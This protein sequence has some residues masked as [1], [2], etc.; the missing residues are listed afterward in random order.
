VGV[1]VG[2]HEVVEWFVWWLLSKAFVF[3]VVP[4]FALVALLASYGNLR[5]A[6]DRQ[7]DDRASRWIRRSDDWTPD[8]TT[9]DRYAD[10]PRDPRP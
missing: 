8:S 4:L 6:R 5:S 9:W 10:D 2:Q 7:H 3:V 1:H